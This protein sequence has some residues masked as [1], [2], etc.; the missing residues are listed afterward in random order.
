MRHMEKKEELTQKKKLTSQIKQ[1]MNYNSNSSKK[2]L[3]H[4][5]CNKEIRAGV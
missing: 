2:R 1:E 5:K 4:S 3:K